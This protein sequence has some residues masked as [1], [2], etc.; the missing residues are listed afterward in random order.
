MKTEEA[1]KKQNASSTNSKPVERSPHAKE[2]GQHPPV[3]GQSFIT[4]LF[5]SNV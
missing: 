5:A 4:I 2:V 1:A 3:G